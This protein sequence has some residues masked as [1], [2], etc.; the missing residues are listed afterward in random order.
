MSS[1]PFSAFWKPLFTCCFLF[2][3]TAFAQGQTPSSDSSGF[4]RT[5]RHKSLNQIE[6]SLYDPFGRPG[7]SDIGKQPA[8]WDTPD[9]QLRTSGA[10]SRGVTVG[11]GRDMSVD[12]YLNLHIQGML[13][14]RV[15]LSA[16]I[17]DR[18]L[19]L[20]TAS[21]MQ[22]KE[23][24]RVFIRLDYLSPKNNTLRLLAGDVDLKDEGGY[25]MRFSRQG[26]GANIRYAT[27]S[28]NFGK[29]GM[30]VSLTEAVAKGTFH[31]QHL[32]ARE[33]VQGGYRLT[34]IH[35]EYQIIVLSSSEKVYIDGVLLRRGEDADYT[36]DYQLAEITF[37]ARQPITRDKR[38]VVEFEYSDQQYVRSLTHLRSV[39][40]REAWRFS[41]DFY[42]EQDLKHQS[43]QL[44]LDAASTAFLQA[45]DQ[46]GTAYYPSADSVGYL[47][48][49]LLYRLTDTIV[50]G[51]RYDSV[52]VYSTD[53]TLA[54]Y[55]LR[56]SYMGEGK[57]HYVS[58][59]GSLNG[60]V[61]AWV[62]PVQGQL[63]GS[64]E[65]VLLLS[66]PQRRQ[67]YS[68]RSEYNGKNS[69]FFAEAAL[70][71][72]DANTF[73]KSDLPALGCAFRSRFQ[74]CWRW[75]SGDR[76]WSLSPMLHYEGKAARFGA[77]DDY[78]NVEF[79]RDFNLSDSIYDKKGEHYAEAS[80]RMES[81]R[82]NYLQWQTT[83]FAIP[84][85]DWSAIRHQ[86][87]LKERLDGFSA[88]ADARLLETHAADYRTVFLKHR[89]VISQRASFLQLGLS[90]EMEWNRYLALPSDSMMAESRA[91]N[92]WSFFVK[93]SDT[94]AGDLQYMLRYAQRNDYSVWQQQLQPFSS[95]SQI[96]ADFAFLKFR[97]HPLRFS[98]SYRSLQ[99]KDS[100]FTPQDAVQSLLGSFD[101]QSR[102]ARGA[103]QSGCYYTLGSAMENKIGYTYLKVADGQGMY[104]WIDYNGNGV[105][106]L[107]EFETALYRDQANYVRVYLTNQDQEK[108][109]ATT[110]TQ[111]LLLR[112]EAV[113]RNS[114]GIR[115][116]LARFSNSTTLQ[117][118][119][120]KST[121]LVEQSDAPMAVLLNPV[122]G[123]LSDSSLRS[124][125]LQF[126]NLFSFHP[127]HPV[128]GAEALYQQQQNKYF[129]VNG[130]EYTS[131]ESWQFSARYRIW[132][133]LQ[134]RASFTR[135]GQSA[136]SS[137]LT[138]RNYS[139]VGE[140][141]R[142]GLQ[143]AASSRWS[144]SLAYSYRWQRNESGV[145]SLFANSVEGE[146]ACRMTGQGSLAVKCR[147]EHLQFHGDSHTTVA[148]TMM[149]ALSDGPNGV[150]NCSY[151]VRLGEYLQLDCQY[152]GR[153]STEGLR[154][155]GTVTVKAVF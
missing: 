155:T 59:Q 45:L 20:Q 47:P 42:N 128:Y 105:E 94:S 142:L 11:N 73:S 112:P 68:F 103:V 84:A 16:H 57:G 123:D 49:E 99:S 143:Y 8:P 41:F 56:F 4:S 76:K 86:L 116:F 23:F 131:S 108:V 89:E 38:I 120:K 29:K 22:L 63:Q 21:T 110:W 97:E 134:A 127:S 151:Q 62:A 150:L 17:S 66:T 53:D 115:C 26:L 67:M 121:A 106:E 117:S 83:A 113:W 36:I 111:R 130:F 46:G 60:Q 1:E 70:S 9:A 61:Y 95:A 19:P 77:V 48:N 24:D 122:C 144:M 27:D 145:E 147:F 104:Q 43:G 137:Y 85:S 44:E 54:C 125:S 138:A 32:V 119:L 15:T 101:W 139:L 136:S 141:S 93:P 140:R 102:W 79:V 7:F 132:R 82:S 25:F 124:G 149:E 13:S 148:Y 72:H 81:P 75:G 88:E 5:F 58:V 92:E 78:R 135:G 87:L 12:S 55:R 118:Q 146:A 96:Q 90:E 133:N 39:A 14:D 2:L 126:R 107:E 37:T 28:M 35:G 10:I 109:Y 33:G 71:N 100:L 6:K 129:T 40:G 51:V 3:L 74:T 80:L 69:I 30:S 98:L 34:G 65:P 91:Y 52:F 50:G 18:N 31:R 152:E 154:H 153:L 114:G 64:Y